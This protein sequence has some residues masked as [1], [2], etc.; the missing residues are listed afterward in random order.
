MSD[1][2][3]AAETTSRRDALIEAGLFIENP[4]QVPGL[5]YPIPPERSLKA[6]VR[7]YETK[8]TLGRK[9][10]C[11]ACPTHTLHYR[12]FVSELDDGTPALVGIVCGERH[13]GEGIWAEM[14]AKLV[15]EQDRAHY[16]ARLGPALRQ[17][18]LLHP[19]LRE[20]KCALAAWG[21]FCSDL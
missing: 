11:A 13:F 21:V 7:E 5:V 15:R 19:L 18:E 20:W 16:L 8:A 12:G 3:F 2:D 14:R 17:I 1:D 10:R 6:L 9:V 4:E